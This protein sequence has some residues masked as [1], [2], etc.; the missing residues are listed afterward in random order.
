MLIAAA[1]VLY[2]I[3]DHDRVHECRKENSRGRRQV[4]ELLL[5]RAIQLPPVHASDAELGPDLLPAHPL[6][7][8]RRTPVPVAV[9]AS[10]ELPLRLRITPGVRREPP[11]LDRLHQRCHVT[12]LTGLFERRIQILVVPLEDVAIGAGGQYGPDR[13]RRAGRVRQ[14]LGLPG[15]RRG[16]QLPCGSPFRP[17]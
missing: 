17:A 12:L 5:S 7:R 3:H 15:I 14:D 9:D 13:R 1:L 10:Q 4:G 8:R 11:A 2:R 16:Q 6:I